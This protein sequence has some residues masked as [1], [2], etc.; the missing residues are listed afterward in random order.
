MCISYFVN[1]FVSQNP[2]P[3]R[4][5]VIANFKK[6]VVGKVEPSMAQIHQ[7]RSCAIG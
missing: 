7:W 4:E 3:E 6:Q 1:P 5:Q 2:T